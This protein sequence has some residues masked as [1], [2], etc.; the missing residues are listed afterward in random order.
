[1]YSAMKM[2]FEVSLSVLHNECYDFVRAS[3]CVHIDV[4]TL[5]LTP[6]KIDRS[7]I[8]GLNLHPLKTRFYHKVGVSPRVFI[9]FVWLRC[10]NLSL[11][12][13]I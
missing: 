1:M 3:R 4:K 6:L 13:N 11:R 7:P 9:A 5:H 12:I 10:Q 8:N 2:F